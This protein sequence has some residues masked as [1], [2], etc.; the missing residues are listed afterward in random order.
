LRDAL[1][2]Q[3]SA[4]LDGGARRGALLRQVAAAGG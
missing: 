2:S 4:K 1:M 3:K